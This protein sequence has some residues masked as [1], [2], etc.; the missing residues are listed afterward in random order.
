M[1]GPAMGASGAVPMGESPSPIGVSEGGSESIPWA[2]LRPPR[3]GD[4]PHVGAR[5][6]GN[7]V[8][9][10]GTTELWLPAA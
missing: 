8:C 2:L 10:V 9:E 7:P 5:I 1:G 3:P 4:H 6:D